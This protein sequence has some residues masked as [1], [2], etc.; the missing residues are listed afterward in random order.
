MAIIDKENLEMLIK[1][2]NLNIEL[3]RQ[4]DPYR[5]H[6]GRMH[7]SHDDSAVE[8]DD[9][10]K[11]F[12]AAFDIPNPG[13]NLF[14]H[15]FYDTAE[16][17]MR[18]NE[19]DALND[20]LKFETVDDDNFIPQSAINSLVER[21][22]IDSIIVSL[23]IN[24]RLYEENIRESIFNTYADYIVDEDVFYF[25]PNTQRLI[26]HLV[27]DETMY[28]PF[29]TDLWMKLVDLAEEIYKIGMRD[30]IYYTDYEV[31]LIL[32]LI[33]LGFADATISIYPVSY[34][35]TGYDDD[36]GF[37]IDNIHADRV[38]EESTYRSSANDETV[39]V[40]F[41]KDMLK[42]IKKMKGI[43]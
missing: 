10:Y 21:S 27:K 4:L 15:I 36:T 42:Y 33:L 20:M 24:T 16:F 5:V 38:A 22:P 26:S 17:V 35:V 13:E 23:K 41:D 25:A 18:S 12:Y 32:I 11:T 3:C 14:R 9:E 30:K 43:N 40:K 6:G 8:K 39:N 7:I 31:Q 34:T 2:V 29:S 37:E 19:R 28:H 1:S